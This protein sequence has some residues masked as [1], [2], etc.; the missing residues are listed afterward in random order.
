MTPKLWFS[1][2]IHYEGGRLLVQRKQGEPLVTLRVINPGGSVKSLCRLRPAEL[3]E[4]V[5]ALK[6]AD[7]GIGT[8][9]L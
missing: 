6:D 1:K 7:P 8:R 3:A 4:L 5:T 9:N 2:M